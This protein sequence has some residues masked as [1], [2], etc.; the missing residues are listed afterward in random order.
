MKERGLWR[1]I[2]RRAERL[3]RLRRFAVLY[4][5]WA[6][7][8]LRAIRET[9]ACR[10]AVRALGSP[11]A[12]SDGGRAVA[13]TACWIVPDALR[14]SRW[15]AARRLY[16]EDIA[17]G[18]CPDRGIQITERNAQRWHREKG[19]PLWISAKRPRVNPLDALTRFEARHP[20][21]GR[22]LDR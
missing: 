9:L 3:P 11:V 6:L 20:F 21:T 13:A 10:M 8:V 19:S 7:A 4:L 16:L 15:H 12:G 17:D 22:A 18:V 14:H 5:C 1:E 2:E